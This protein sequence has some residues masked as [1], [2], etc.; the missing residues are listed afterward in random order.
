MRDI[1]PVKEAINEFA[2]CFLVG[3]HVAVPTQH[4]YPSNGSVTVFVD[5]A[6]VNTY[7][8]TD[9][10]GAIEELSALGL[11][12]SNP[13][14]VFRSVCREY[15]VDTRKG[16]IQAPIVPLEGLS[17]AIVYVATAS[18]RA[19]E[20][21]LAKLKSVRHRDLTEMVRGV[22]EHRFSLER[23][24]DQETVLGASNRQYTFD[25][26]V[27]IP[28]DGKLLV[29]IVVPEP[30]S[31]NSKVVSHIDVSKNEDPNLIQR[32]VFDDEEDWR[33]SDLS[34]LQMAATT[35]PFSHFGGNLDRLVLH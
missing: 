14:S 19:A 35:V 4:L 1:G 20:H 27:E 34:L 8:V 12:V 13:D 11:T 30:P 26:S 22:L 31:I 33:A 5:V 10:G 28:G 7:Q 6:H 18:A 29:D 2:D 9:N 25:F 15:G 32:I 24:H 3:N 23:L 16:V 17:S 21:G